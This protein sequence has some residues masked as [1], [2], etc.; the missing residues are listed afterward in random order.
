M[1]RSNIL[2]PVRPTLDARVWLHAGDPKPTLRPLHAHFITRHIY[3]ILIRGGYSDPERWLK[4][5]FTGSLCTYQYSDSSDADVSL[6]IDSSKLPEWSR[7]EMIGLMVE[8]CDGVTLPATPYE[9]QAYVVSPKIKPGD[10][11]KPGLRPGYDI[12]HHK[13]IEPPTHALEH[14][15]QKQEEGFYAWALQGA[16]KM[17]KLLRYEPDK[18]VDYWHQIHRK[19]MRDQTAGKGDFSESNILYKF[20]FK[21]G[22]GKQLAD[23]TGEHIGKVAAGEQAM[24]DANAGN[25]LQGLPG[26]VNV[27]GYGPLQFH[28]NADIQRIANEYNAANGLDVHPMDYLPVNPDTGARIAQEYE[29]MA[30]APQDPQVAQAYQALAQE[31]MAQYQHAVNNGYRFEFYP[32]GQDPYPNSPREAVMDLHKNKHMYVYPTAAG[33]GTDD[34][35]MDHPLLQDSGV[36]WNGQPVT[37]NDIFRA[38]HDFYGHAKEGLGF[39]HHGEDNAYRQHAAMFSPPAR[40]ALA[41]E[42][43]GQNS[44]VNFGPYGQNNQTATQGETV[45]APQ[46]AGLLPEWVS[47]PDLHRGTL[48]RIAS[49]FTDSIYQA[50]L[51]NGGIT[52]GLNGEPAPGQGYAFAPQKDSEF[53]TPLASLTPATIDQY[54]SE[55]FTDLSAPGRYLGAWVDGNDVY[56]DVTTVEPDFNKAHQMAWDANQLAMWDLGNNAEVPVQRSGDLLPS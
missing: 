34:Q 1:I 4:L 55:Y 14:D 44:W 40:A 48:A 22:L 21:R 2:D 36:R 30:H 18:A 32:Q 39:R 27:H 52:I 38:I 47:N 37:H 16:D 33:Y 17:E 42:T 28:S 51:Q 12:F 31:S 56:L 9:L 23:L 50:I 25:D 24:L 49:S 15:V 13:W 10:L 19:R 3:G 11:Y 45:Y 46:K 53:V 29:Q 7:A 5:Y 20:L 41:S 8:G 35:G 54:I 43:R 26:P 6:F